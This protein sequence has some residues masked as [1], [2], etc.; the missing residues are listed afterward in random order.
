MEK[1]Y[2]QGSGEV[3]EIELGEGIERVEQG[4]KKTDQ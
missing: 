2:S 3:T 4:N 1:E